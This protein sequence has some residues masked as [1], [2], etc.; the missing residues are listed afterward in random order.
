VVLPVKG[1]DHVGCQSDQVKL[2]CALIRD[3]DEAMNEIY[4]LGDHG[5]EASRRITEMEALCK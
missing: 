3:L 1:R 5:E 4:Q 2:T